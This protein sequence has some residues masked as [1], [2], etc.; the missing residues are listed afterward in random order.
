VRTSKPIIDDELEHPGNNLPPL[1]MAVSRAT[2]S[3]RNR[4]AK[5]PSGDTSF[6]LWMIFICLL[7]AVA[8][9]SW[10]G[11][12]YIFG[13]P[14]KAFNYAIL[15]KAKKV[16]PP[17]KFEITGA[18]RG[19]FLN[20]DQIV[21]KYQALGPGELS[22]LN[23]RLLRNYLRN[24]GGSSEHVPYVSGSF[25][26]MDSFE[27]TGSNLFPSGIVA[28]AQSNDNPKV[29]LEHAYPADASAIPIL[30]RML[31]TGTEL[32]LEKRADRSVDISAILHV[33]KLADGKLKVTAVPLV[34]GTYT[35]TAA[36]GPGTFSLSPPEV[37]N[38]AAGLPILGKEM[39]DDAERK[40]LVFR[41]RAGLLDP[42]TA[43]TAPKR[44]PSQFV[45]V[46]PAKPAGGGAAPAATAVVASGSPAAQAVPGGEPTVLPAIPLNGAVSVP[47]PTPAETPA[48][49]NPPQIVASTARNWQTYPA[50]QAPRGRVAAVSEMSDLADRGVGGDRVY[51]QG[52]FTVRASGNNRAVLRA[53]NANDLGIGNQSVVR[54]I[55]D[56]PAGAPLPAEGDAV[57]RDSRRPFL[58]TR[59]QKAADGTINVF[60]MEITKP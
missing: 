59:V 42:A 8:I 12:I 27:L 41:K 22:D 30:H 57:E 40:L 28:L 44:P 60:A 33:Q 24:F 29:F 53:V 55:V 52:G 18:P 23:D 49:A 34:Y 1:S 17:K 19:E 54:V 5:K 58:V 46:E 25:T 21:E 36:D 16:E 45:R 37:L 38:V 10:I 50:G 7:I 35:S 15:L 39:T 26:I 48:V 6:F 56:Y 20:A 9:A 11:S 4:P 13:H 47:S 3:G 31:L 32:H 51:L 14:E 43:Q 2:S